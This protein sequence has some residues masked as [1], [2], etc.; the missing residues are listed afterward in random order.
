MCIRDRWC[1]DLVLLMEDDFVWCPHFAAALEQ[2]LG[3]SAAQFPHWAGGRIGFGMNG[4][5]LRCEDIQ[6]VQRFLESNIRAGPA[7]SMLGAFWTSD[8]NGLS[9][10]RNWLSSDSEHSVLRSGTGT[11]HFK[12]RTFWSYKYNLLRHIGASSTH[13]VDSHYAPSVLPQCMDS[14]DMNGVMLREKFDSIRCGEHD[15][16]PCEGWT[17]P[18]GLVAAATAKWRR[19]LNSPVSSVLAGV[20]GQSCFATCA[21][22][23]QMCIPEML[24]LINNCPLL[25]KYFKCRECRVHDLSSDSSKSRNPAFQF[26]K[27]CLVSVT[28]DLMSCEVSRPDLAPLCPCAPPAPHNT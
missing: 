9:W 5:V 3:L 19:S 16:S 21:Q 26:P 10:M 23:G 22:Q 20:L 2:A 13:K 12:G 15:L 17:A 4:V 28:P 6:T 18:I 14:L 8:P 11:D 24:P 27:T 25:T 1:T 7:D